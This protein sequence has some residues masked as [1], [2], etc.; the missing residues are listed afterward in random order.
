VVVELEHYNILVL[1]PFAVAVSNALVSGVGG[2]EV[3]SAFVLRLKGESS[4][5]SVIIFD[6]PCCSSDVLDSKRCRPSEYGNE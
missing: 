5:I 2:D 1:S 6:N 4:N 3:I